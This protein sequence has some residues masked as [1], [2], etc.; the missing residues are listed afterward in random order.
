MKTVD[1]CK[2]PEPVLNYA[3]ADYSIRKIQI[4][5]LEQVSAIESK[6]F[7]HPWSLTNILYEI[8]ENPL[9]YSLV[10]EENGKI[11]GYIIGW[12]LDFEAHVGTFAIDFE[13]RRNKIGSVLLN[14]FT[15][16]LK[17]EGCQVFHLEVRR[18]NVAARNLYARQGFIISGMRKNY[19]TKEKEDAL[20]MS[21]S[22]QEV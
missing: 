18:S 9:A 1:L 11:I 13:Y 8:Q 19:Y 15:D 10:V 22:L 6:T 14:T 16:N 2:L 21:L 20:L 3:I 4:K 12:Y 17:Y 5:D 7:P